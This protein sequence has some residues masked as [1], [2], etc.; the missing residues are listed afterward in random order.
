MNKNLL[1]VS[2]AISDLQ[3]NR[4]GLTGLARL[5]M[6]LTDKPILITDKF[7]RV[8][9]WLCPQ[10]QDIDVGEKVSL[11]HHSV[12]MKGE[13]P[14]SAQLILDEN[15]YNFLSW[16]LTSKNSQGFL[17]LFAEKTDLTAEMLEL[18]ELFR[19]AI[20]I[21]LAHQS[22]LQLTKQAFRDDF[23]HDLIFNNFDTLETI[24]NRGKLWGWKSDKIYVVL[25]MEPHAQDKHPQK[26]KEM[27]EEYEKVLSAAV[28]GAVM[29][30][31]SS[32]YVVLI[33]L[34]QLEKDSWKEKMRTVYKEMVGENNTD[35]IY[36]GAG[37]CYDTPDQIYRSFQEAKVALELGNR[38]NRISRISFF[39]E[40]GAVRL[41]Y[42]QTEQE[43]DDFIDE[44][45]KPMIDY[46]KEN[47]TSLLQTLWEF[48]QA[49]LDFHIAKERLFIH[50]NTLRY[51]LKKV[52]EILQI[53]LNDQE[54]RFNLYAALKVMV[55][56]KKI[57]YRN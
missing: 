36:A 29:G 23:I 12:S 1:S 52:E 24:E 38:F 44:N 6:Q 33:P 8:L 31:V 39:D 15:T 51:R 10:N 2:Q 4:T 46:D 34:S 48:F 9:S 28:K 43:L 20:M 56:R 50:I 53:D 57:N 45:L 22:E 5:L 49:N 16:S 27:R 19:S 30:I 17:V 35:N 18:I 37:K 3:L 11:L 55:L 26:A 21:E 40:L 47:D 13:T 25:V 32:L 54:Q 14:F 41:F 42:N 7:G